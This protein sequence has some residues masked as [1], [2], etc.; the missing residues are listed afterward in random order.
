MAF[1][2]LRKIHGQMHEIQR[3]IERKQRQKDVL[4][5]STPETVFLV[6]TPIHPN[7]GDSAIVLAERAFLNK[8]LPQELTFVEI[9]DDSLRRNRELAFQSI[10][11]SGKLP[12]LWHGGGNMGDLWAGQERL[13]RDVF[14]SFRERRIISFPQTIFYSDTEKGQK[15]AEES[16]PYYNGKAGL[17]L[18]AREFRSFEIM[19]SLYPDTDVRLMPDIVLSSSAEEFG[20]HPQRREGILMC[21]R[22]DVEK[23]IPDAVWDE[24]KAH[25]GKLEEK[26]R[27]TDMGAKGFIITPETR[28]EIVRSK[29]QEFRGAKLAITDRLHGMVF[30][31]LTGTP[32]V[33]F[34][35]YNHKVRS[36]YDWLSYL[37][38]IR[39]AETLEEAERC[40]PEL[41]AMENCTFDNAPLTP[42]FEKLKEMILEACM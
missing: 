28:A 5:A 27:V 35:N 14:L 22:N 17:T 31:A 3:E 6:G 30:A 15:L 40:I 32:C 8:I 9:T 23:S 12:I 42:Y 26:Y 11:K 16:I 34:S 37:P 2:R 10:Q 38:Y 1:Y 18:T 41:L 24:F 36:T 25:L 39:Y 20:V 7:I 33:V 4:R 13:R 29:M 19:K 21:L